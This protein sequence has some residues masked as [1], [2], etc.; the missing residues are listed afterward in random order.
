MIDEFLNYLANEK[1]F[2]P[3][4]VVAYKKDIEQFLES[5][6]NDALSLVTHQ[7][8]RA[9]LVEMV[10]EGKAMPYLLLSALIQLGFLIWSITDWKK[11]MIDHN[12]DRA[13]KD[14]LAVR[15]LEARCG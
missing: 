13:T 6:E 1:R 4:T 3:H 12:Y 10:E 11:A 15:T 2:S 9:Y 14:A 7:D 5:T 8:I